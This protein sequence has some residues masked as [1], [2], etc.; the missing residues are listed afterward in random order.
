MVVSRLFIPEWLLWCQAMAVGQAASHERRSDAE[1][2]QFHE[3]PPGY[4]TQA[5]QSAERALTASA[6]VRLRC[7]ATPSSI[8]RIAR[9]RWR[10]RFDDSASGVGSPSRTTMADFKNLLWVGWVL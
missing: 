10:K 8:V 3:K 7:W 5:A 9:R 4:E 2:N 1:S 6:S